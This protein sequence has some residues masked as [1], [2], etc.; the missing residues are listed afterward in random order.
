M[1]AEDA[2][3]KVIKITEQVHDKF[4]EESLKRI[5]RRTPVR[6]GAAKKGWKKVK[7]GIVNNIAYVKFL[8]IGSRF[9]RPVGMVRTTA[10]EADSI[11]KKVIRKLGG[12]K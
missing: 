12:G 8:E 4:L 3:D 5:Q 10:A 7:D 9:K 1:K 11:L 2:I 6:T